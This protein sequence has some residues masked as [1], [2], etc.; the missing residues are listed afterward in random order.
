MPNTMFTNR[1]T[2]EVAVH[3][4]VGDGPCAAKA[5]TKNFRLRPDESEAVSTEY[6]VCYTIGLTGE[7]PP[8]TAPYREANPGS[9]IEIK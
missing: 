3:T 7:L 4:K 2:N 8:V 9:T 1:R 6:T 5:T